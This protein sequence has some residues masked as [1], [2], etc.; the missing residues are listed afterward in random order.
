MGGGSEGR[1]REK[2]LVTNFKIQQLKKKIA[3]DNKRHQKFPL[4]PTVEE[5]AGETEERASTSLNNL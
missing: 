2:C 4:A 1:R 3:N 5:T